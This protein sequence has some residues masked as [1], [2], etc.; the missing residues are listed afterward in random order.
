MATF[1][2]GGDTK[3]TPESIKRK[4]DIARALLTSQAPRNVGEG[5]NALG[6]GIVSAVLNSRADKGEAAGRA[7][8]EADR[9]AFLGG[10]ETDAPTSGTRAD[11]G[12]PAAADALTPSPAGNY[13]DA[14]ASIESAG[15]GDYAAVGPTHPKMGRA[16]GRYQ[17]MESNIGPWSEAAL[18][19]QVSADEFMSNPE[20]QDK[21]FD[22]QFG[23]Y[24]A[25][26]GPE[27]AAQAWFGGP[28]GVG[29]L[30]RKDSLGTTIAG[31]TDKFRN[32][33]GG[34]QVASLDPSLSGAQTATDAVNIMA[35]GGGRE[36]PAFAN[37]SG[38]AMIDPAAIQ[39]PAFDAGRWGDPIKL[40]EMPASRADLPAN[41]QAQAENPR[42]A[43]ANAL[44]ANPPPAAGP[45]PVASALVAPNAGTVAQ[46][47]VNQ[48][49]AAP[50]ATPSAPVTVAQASPR[51]PSMQQ[52]YRLL[53]N[54][55]ASEADRALAMSVIERQQKM[56][57]PSYQL[58][59]DIRRAQLEKL[60]R[61]GYRIATAEERQSFGI[62][63]DDNRPYQIGPEGQ[64]TAI[65]G[66]GQ[67]Q[68]PGAEARQREA[69]AS[70]YGIDP[71]SAE[72]QRFIL[73]GTLPTSDKGVTAGDREAIRD[74]DDAV[75]TGQATIG[76]LDR[77]MELSDKAYEGV[78]AGTR[79]L[80]ASQFGDEGALATREFDNIIT[81]Q[82]LG[83][84]KAIFGGAPTE[85]ERAILLEIQGSSSQPKSVRDNILK[86]AKA[87][88]ERRV[89]FNTDRATELRGGTYYRP[90]NGA[91]A[92][93]TADPSS[94]GGRVAPA[95][96]R[97]RAKNQ[98]T[99]E[100]IE[101]DGTN[102]VPVK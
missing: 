84:L 92:P 36:P 86:R 48:A 76:L 94:K 91:A 1:I 4:R 100:V 17:V 2:F 33:M 25:K 20:I 16:L 47:P 62:P 50:Q 46:T 28:G 5:L 21:I 85:G 60:Q 54:P 61:P 89:N 96:A 81:E 78:G 82:A 44:A 3:E 22:H 35:G 67:A 14:I 24:V 30:N 45:S 59:Q 77:A 87:A 66:Q 57:D 72:G 7:S 74:A 63:S 31:Y 73:T 99:G 41:L 38:N 12:T 65:G 8:A 43:V 80:V 29:K 90:R 93:E 75:M 19:R 39:E 55:Y 69:L 42:A 58:D 18:G 11:I 52:A 102:W 26:Y 32:A 10:F 9:A 97:P 23:Q 88:V 51:G 40:A 37:P 68:S 15:S 49:L 27:G 34:Q 13:R 101:F 79:A 56:S 70:Q 71:K 83:Q 98:Q 64:I 95:A 53:N 6:D